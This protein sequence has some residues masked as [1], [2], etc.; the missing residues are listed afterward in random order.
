MRKKAIFRKE[1]EFSSF[2][3]R[4]QEPT[5]IKYGRSYEMQRKPLQLSLYD[6][7]GFLPDEVRKEFTITIG[8]KEERELGV[9]LLTLKKVD[10]ALRELL[11]I[12]SYQCGNTTEYTGLAKEGMLTDGTVIGK[13]T[14]DGKEYNAA[15][16]KVKIGDLAERALGNDSFTNR[17][18]VEATLK[19]MQTGLT[20]RSV[21]GDEYRRSLLW[22]KGYDYDRKTK[23]K[24]QTIVLTAIYSKDIQNNFAL[25]RNGV[26]GLLGKVTDAKIELLSLLGI[27]D[28][29]KPFVRY[30]YQLLKDLGLEE[31]YRQRKKR[32]MK[33]I[34]DANSAMVMCGIIT[35]LPKVEKDRKG[36]ALKF[37]YSL[38]PDYGK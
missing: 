12:Q 37:T 6:A 8:E 26:L 28:K 32:A 38:N 34:E 9:T 13:E 18:I 30:L 16:I 17:K 21:Y 3:Q 2:P 23:A 24:Y 4:K 25:H 27:Q 1:D 36:N 10:F 31:E 22:L 14:I 15:E 11:Y 33:K 29:R 35:Q 7:I 5:S 20:C 19:A